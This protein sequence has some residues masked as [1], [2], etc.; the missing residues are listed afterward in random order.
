V[1]KKERK[2]ENKK[3][4]VF[5]FG[6]WA[7]GGVWLTSRGENIMKGTNNVN[8]HN[9]RQSLLAVNSEVF[10]YYYLIVTPILNTMNSA[11]SSFNTY[12]LLT[13]RNYQ[14]LLKTTNSS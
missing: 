9:R 4:Q 11:M 3:D 12:F 10:D 8:L 14:G 5:S 7:S 6:I 1:K 2:G 13:H